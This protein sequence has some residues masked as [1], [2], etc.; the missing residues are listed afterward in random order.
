[1]I[2]RI[3]P[4]TFQ[5]PRAYFTDFDYTI[6]QF[7]HDAEVYRREVE[8]RLKIILLTKKNIVCA[9]S[10][11]AS[12]FAYSIF[13]DNSILLA[14]KMVIPALREDKEHVTDYLKGKRIKSSIKEK[15][16]S[17]YES[18][19]EEVVNWEFMENVAWFR[20]KILAALNDENSVIRRNLRG[21]PRQKI[22]S[23]VREIQKE[24][25]VTRDLILK[26]IST[27]SPKEQRTLLNFV[28]LVY[29]ISGARVVNCESALPQESYIDYSL[30]DFSM[31]RTKLSETQ[32]FL[33]IFF[34]LA[35][36][37]LNKNPLPVALLDELSFEDIYY[38]RKPLEN[39]AFQKKYDDLI[40]NCIQIVR[41]AEVDTGGVMY[42]IAK[43]IEIIDKISETFEEIFEKELPEF[44]NKKRKEIT[45]GL[46]KSALSLGLGVADVA[47]PILSP[48]ITPLSLASSSRELLINLN[49]YFK[50]GK[51]LKDYNSYLKRKERMLHQFIQKY[52]ISEK[53]TFLDALDL[54]T[55]TLLIKLS[56]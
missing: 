43:P 53:S 13:K 47:V 2:K 34:E 27:W 3:N 25:V 4:I 41:S 10:H 51:E 20:G 21:I 1:M 18:H 30:T 38:L 28:N 8:R 48:I 15:M 45:K 14:Q 32:V 40:Q 39:S 16:Q 19:V 44:L 36:E 29:H 49:Q 17:F 52:P 56:V 23:L 33:K 46:R 24:N 6:V 22:N 42:D 55:H 35:F 26:S 12:E 31:R 7:K 9:A 11:L 54:L 50:S 5:G 37:I